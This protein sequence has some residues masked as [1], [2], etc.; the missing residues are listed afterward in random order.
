MFRA[1]ESNIAIGSGST[2]GIAQVITP[3]GEM[4]AMS[5]VNE[6]EFIVGDTFI[7]AKQ[8]FY[9]KYG[10]VFAYILSTCF[11]LFFMVSEKTR[12]GIVK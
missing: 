10:D 1:V 2:N 3:F 11:V 7:V 8:T 5:G 6:R 12:L 9:T 4:T